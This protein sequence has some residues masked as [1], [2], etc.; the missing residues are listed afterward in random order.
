MSFMLHSTRNHWSLL[1]MP[2]PC[3][4]SYLDWTW[5]KHFKMLPQTQHWPHITWPLL[6]RPSS[7]LANNHWPPHMSW[8]DRSPWP[9]ASAALNWLALPLLQPTIPIVGSSEQPMISH[10]QCSSLLYETCCIN[11]AIFTQQ[12]TY[13]KTVSN[14]RQQLTKLFTMHNRIPFLQIW[15]Q[16]SLPTSF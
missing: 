7:R 4:S 11:L 8:F 14:S 16:M 10:H 6:I 2:T 12:I 15:L 5:G 9:P 13:K 1:V 3:T